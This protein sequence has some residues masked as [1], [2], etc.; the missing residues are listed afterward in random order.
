MSLHGQGVPGGGGRL[1]GVD[2]QGEKRIGLG[3]RCGELEEQ[4]LQHLPGAPALA[5]LGAPGTRGC[6]GL[7][8]VA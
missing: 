2:C 1:A 6:P 3:G 5:A 7:E 8:A 4:L